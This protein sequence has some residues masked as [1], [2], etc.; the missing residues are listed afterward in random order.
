[1][2]D[3][4]QR[5]HNR[6]TSR[7]SGQIRPLAPFPDQQH[8]DADEH[9]TSPDPST[10][11]SESSPIEMRSIGDVMSKTQVL[12]EELDS[13]R[14]EYDVRVKTLMRAIELLEKNE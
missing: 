4:H 2:F 9:E 3:H 1:M 5:V 12:R 14:K 11:F 8:E 13:V 7:Q 10:R 6:A